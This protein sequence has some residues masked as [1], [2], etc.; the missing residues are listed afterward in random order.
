MSYL[1]K[2]MRKVNIAQLCPTIWNPLDYTVHGIL[3]VRIL[4]WTA[5]HFLMA[6]SQPKDWTQ[7]PYIAGKFF[8]CWATREAQE[9]WNG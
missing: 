1:C 9:Y 6:S 4:E 5:F 8:K 7:A 2:Y 3:Q